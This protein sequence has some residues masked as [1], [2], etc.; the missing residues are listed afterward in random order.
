M[1]MHVPHS[2]ATQIGN[3]FWVPNAPL[4]ALSRKLAS[5][6]TRQKILHHADMAL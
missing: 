2:D 5:R 1:G 4:W 6:K 3:L